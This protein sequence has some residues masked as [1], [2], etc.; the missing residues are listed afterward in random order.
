MLNLISSEDT[1]SRCYMAVSTEIKFQPNKEYVIFFNKKVPTSSPYAS[2][3]YGSPFIST[4]SML[5]FITS[6]AADIFVTM[7][8]SL[9]LLRQRNFQFLIS[10]TTGIFDNIYSF[11][12][13]SYT[14]S[15]SDNI[16]NDQHDQYGYNCRQCIIISKTRL[17]PFSHPARNTHRII[18]I[19]Y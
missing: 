3:M 17:S 6:L 19:Y 4:I 16:I 9:P 1:F 15:I 14:P 11:S 10:Y 18:F 5:S 2:A 7:P 13:H 8:G 12:D